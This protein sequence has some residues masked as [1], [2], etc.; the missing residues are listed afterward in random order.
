ML[1]RYSHRYQLE[2]VPFGIRALKVFC[3]LTCVSALAELFTLVSGIHP[4]LHPS[5]NSIPQNDIQRIIACVIGLAYAPFLYAIHRRF[6]IAW[7]L[8]WVVLIASALWSLVDGVAVVFQT[9]R[10]Q[11]GRSVA[12]AAV[13]VGFSLV[14]AYW[15]HWWNL[16][17]GY[18]DVK[19]DLQQRERLD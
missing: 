16:Q 3:L 10:P 11:D 5:H 8:G 17:K 18:F 13:M 1:Q 4:P 6:R 14:A 15:L 2:E 7:K 12:V 9:L 19:N